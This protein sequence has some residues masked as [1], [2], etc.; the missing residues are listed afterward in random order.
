M[1]ISLSKSQAINV[2]TDVPSHRVADMLKICNGNN[3][4]LGEK[5]KKFSPIS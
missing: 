3:S 5:T 2:P 4:A 1:L